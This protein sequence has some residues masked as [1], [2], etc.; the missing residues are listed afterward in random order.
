M[1]SG[2]DDPR[3]KV[4]I[5]LLSGNL[6]MQLRSIQ[7]LESDIF[8]QQEVHFAPATAIVGSHGSGKTLLMRL[9]EAAFGW[10]AKSPPFV[11]IQYRSEFEPKFPPVLGLLKVTVAI[12][13][14]LIDREVD[15]S[16]TD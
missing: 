16:N 12:G 15:L 4:W 9:I 14:I 2:D 3:I 1:P 10:G 13:D 8:D 11:G 5:R 6:P 7:I